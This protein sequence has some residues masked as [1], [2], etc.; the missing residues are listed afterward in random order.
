[1]GNVR[2]PSIARF[3]ARG[4]RPIRR[5]CTSFAI[6]DVISGNLSKSAV[7]KG[8]GHYERKF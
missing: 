4:R 5:N 3:K 8:V 6:A 2:T 7:S 1:M